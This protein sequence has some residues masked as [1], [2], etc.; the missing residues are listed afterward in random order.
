MKKIIFFLFISVSVF[1]QNSAY[2]VHSYL[3]EGTKAPN[4]HYIGEAWLNAIIH[5]DSELG[6]NITKATFKANSTLD[7]HKHSSAQVLIIVEGN[8]YYQEKGNEPVIL[9]KG[10]VIKCGKDIEHWHSSTKFSDVTY[11]ALY[12]GEQPTTWTEVVTQEYYDGV[13]EKLKND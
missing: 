11:L 10:D 5:D 8:A 3:T 9:K 4:T 1:S 12:S 6:Y 2:Q 7:W 13:A